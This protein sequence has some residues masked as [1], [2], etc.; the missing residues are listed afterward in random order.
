MAEREVAERE[1]PELPEPNTRWRAKDDC[2]IA[3]GPELESPDAQPSV[4]SAGQE[5]LVLATERIHDHVGGFFRFSTKTRV[6][7]AGGWVSHI[8]SVTGL[9]LLEPA[10]AAEARAKEQREKLGPRNVKHPRTE[11]LNTRK[12]ENGAPVSAVSAP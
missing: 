6:R 2:R 7:F 8:D 3:T 11:M 5:I 1:G 12:Q 4:L 9:A 10:S